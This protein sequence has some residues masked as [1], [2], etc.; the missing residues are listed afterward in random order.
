MRSARMAENIPSHAPKDGTT[1]GVPPSTEVSTKTLEQL[2]RDK[3]PDV[4]RAVPEQGVKKLARIAISQTIIRQGPLPDPQELAAYNTIIPNG[5]DRMMKMAESQSEHRIKMEALVIGSQQK[6]T[7]LGQVFALIIALF[8]IS[9]GVFSGV[10]GEPELG[11]V[12]AGGT[13][14]SIVSAFIYGKHAQRKDLMEKRQ[15]LPPP[16]P[17][18]PPR[19]DAGR[20]RRKRR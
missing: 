12:V 9:A 11:G 16:Q 19:S 10:K 8:G 15:Q 1:G 5:A 7:T 13:V 3:A 6:Q 4:L 18:A 14:V 17:Q 20:N 2:L